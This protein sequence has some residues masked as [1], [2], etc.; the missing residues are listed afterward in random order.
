VHKAASISSLALQPNS[1]I[2]AAGSAGT[3]SQS[4]ALARYIT[5]GQLDPSFGSRGLVTTS[6]GGGANADISAMVLQ[7]DGK[8][9]VVGNVNQDSLVVARYLGQ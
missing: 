7:S 2:L 6:F 5:T 1:A 4:F 8:I 9:V 3:S